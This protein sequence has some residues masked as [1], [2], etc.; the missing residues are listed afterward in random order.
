MKWDEQVGDFIVQATDTSY[1]RAD[2][3]Y[4]HDTYEPPRSD[5]LLDIRKASISPVSFVVTFKR[6][7]LE[8]RYH[9]VENVKAASTVNY[10]VKHLKFT[11]KDAK[12]NFR[13]YHIQNVRGPPDRLLEMTTAYYMVSRH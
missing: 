11:V 2:D 8:S 13:G 4:D 6:R 9:Q 5:N 3:K 12:L 10:F 7:P 1:E